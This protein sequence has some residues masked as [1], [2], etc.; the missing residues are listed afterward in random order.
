MFSWSR[1]EKK[2]PAAPAGRRVAA[3]THAPA[4]DGSQHRAARRNSSA[5]IVD[6]AVESTHRR[7]DAHANGARSALQRQH[8]APRL[9]EVAHEEPEVTTKSLGGVRFQTGEIDSQKELSLI[10]FHEII[11]DKV[12]LG[13]HYYS[14]IAVASLAAAGKSVILFVDRSKVTQDDVKAV[15]ELLKAQGFEL[16]AAGAQG[17]YLISTLVISLSQKTLTAGN[18]SMEREIARDKNKNALMAS[19]TDIVSWAYVEKADDIDFVVDSTS[20][21]SQIAFKIG[22]RYVRPDRHLLPTDIIIQMLGIAWQKSN[23]GGAAQFEI[24]TEQQAQISL[25][26]PKSQEVPEGARVRLRW[27]GMANDKGTVVTMRLQRLGGSA[28]IRSLDDAGYLKSQMEI[29][30]R[31]IHSEGGMVVLSGV[32]GSGKS[33]S[34]VQLINMLQ[35]DIKIVTIEDPVELD[36]PTAYQKTVTRDLTSTGHDPAFVAATRSLYRSAMDVLYLGEIRDTETGLVARQVA[37]SGHSVYTTTHA[38]SALGIVDRFASP[39]IG[40]PRDVLGTPDILKLLVYQSLLPTTCPH[41]GKSPDDYAKLMKLK[42]A[43]LDSHQRYFERLHRLYDIEPS[44][45]RLRDRLGCSH[46]RK[47]E[48]PDLDGFSG[49]TVVSELIELDEIMLG[50]IANA[51]NI[52]LVTHWRALSNNK[53]DDDDMTGK[54]TMECAVYKSAQGIIDPREIEPRFMSFETVESKRQ[55]AQRVAQMRAMKA[56]A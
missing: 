34:L 20:S 33:T 16:P 13:P 21:K 25:D 49:R 7:S 24:K 15:V 14:R 44:R 4:S 29:F 2:V 27:S 42:D 1:S 26:I 48:L 32:V 23:G 28:R 46:C 41:C 53:F 52:D 12:K 3:A 43:G 38:R 54:T 40:I 22:G 39:A 31:V 11:N 17:Y 35:K 56:G 36:I 30:K 45:F 8:T 37:E 10:V 6:V 51:K 50:H 55:T 19:F 18:L 9:S 5:G 47:I